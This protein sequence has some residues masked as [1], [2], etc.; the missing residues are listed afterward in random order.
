MVSAGAPPSGPT[1]GR[2]SWRGTWR[3]EAAT[4]IFE[5]GHVE[6]EWSA[7]WKSHELVPVFPSIFVSSDAAV[8]DTGSR[9]EVLSHA[10]LYCDGVS[11]N[12]ARPGRRDGGPV[13]VA[14]EA[15]LLDG[16]GAG[17]RAVAQAARDRLAPCILASGRTALNSVPPASL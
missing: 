17:L 10:A 14:R 4:N 12:V 3:R 6:Y 13:D 2:A 11:R 9:L 16:A 8:Q 5:R 15:V 7:A 1:A